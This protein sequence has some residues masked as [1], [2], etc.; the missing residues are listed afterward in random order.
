MNKQ[1]VLYY[2]QFQTELCPM[3]LIGDE[4]GIQRLY[5]HVVDNKS[6]LTLAE[7]AQENHTFF[8]AAIAQLQAYAKGELEQ[9]D[10]K[11]NPQGTDFQKQ[12][13]QALRQIPFGET[14]SYQAI[15]D[16]INNPKAVRAVGAANGRNPIPII[17]PC[18]RVIGANG[19]LTGFAMGLDMKQR[20]LT[21]E[22]RS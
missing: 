16:Q 3:T 1:N 19:K 21:L 11:L 18:H 20:I 13:W 7:N 15:A 6:P 8:A 4:E 5:C 12:V 9:F 10:L 22:Q 2:A 17:V 14:T